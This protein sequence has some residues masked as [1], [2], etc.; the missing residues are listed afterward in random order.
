MNGRLCCCRFSKRH[1]DESGCED[2]YL[3]E[4]VNRYFGE[5][6]TG[7]RCA[8]EPSCEVWQMFDMRKAAKSRPPTLSHQWLDLANLEMCRAIA[9]KVRRDPGLMRIPRA[10]LRRWRRK[11]GY[12]PPAYREWEAILRHN[13]PGRVL[14]ILTQDNDEGQRLR[15]SDPFVG[16]LTEQER[17][18]CLQL[19]EE[20]PT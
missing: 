2:I 4:R 14:R 1:I 7:E 3:A 6:E 17:A 9:R 11:L 18:A 19:H 5:R 12:W 13:P 15:Q 10:N 8:L 16:I 20:T